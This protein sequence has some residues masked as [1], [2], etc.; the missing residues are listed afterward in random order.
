M[1]RTCVEL[2]ER[3]RAMGVVRVS[4]LPLGKVRKKQLYAVYFSMLE[5]REHDGEVCAASEGD[6]SG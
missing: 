6:G 3:L 4:G 5:R 2:R 1:P